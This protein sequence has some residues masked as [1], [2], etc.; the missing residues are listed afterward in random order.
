LDVDIVLILIIVGAESGGDTE[1]AEREAGG[2][3]IEDR[4][5]EGLCL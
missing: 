1:Q 2:K 4:W 3:L 5:H